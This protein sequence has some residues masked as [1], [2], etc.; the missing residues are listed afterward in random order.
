LFRDAVNAVVA[1]GFNCAVGCWALWWSQA[2]SVIV[3]DEMWLLLTV[4]VNTRTTT[5]GVLKN[6]HQFYECP[7]NGIKVVM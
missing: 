2:R 3:G 4:Y 5:M 7:L 6:P 1:L